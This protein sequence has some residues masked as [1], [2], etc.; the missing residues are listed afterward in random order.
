MRL[1]AVT[2]QVLQRLY[3][4]LS[5]SGCANGKG[6]L[7]SRSVKL[8]HTVLHLALGR[9]ALWRLIPGNPAA[10]R[11]D[12][13]RQARREMTMWTAEEARR[14]LN[15][16]KDDRLSAPVG[17]DARHRDAPERSPRAPAGRRWTSPEAAWPS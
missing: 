1:Q 6:G 8:A 7:S 10:L 17:A 4:D 13:P 5:E 14:F 11:L 3:A 2:P 16:T 9:A 12:L 15:A